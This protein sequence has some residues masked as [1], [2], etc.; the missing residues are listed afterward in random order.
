MAAEV[1]PEEEFRPQQLASE[2]GATALHAVSEPMAE[3]APEPVPQ[4]LTFGDIVFNTGP[5]EGFDMQGFVI[6]LWKQRE[7]L[8]AP[9]TLSLLLERSRL[10]Q[11]P[12][13][14]ETAISTSDVVE[15]ATEKFE[16]LLAKYSGSISQALVS[17]EEP[18]ET[19]A[20]HPLLVLTAALSKASQ[21]KPALKQLAAHVHRIAIALVLANEAA[22]HPS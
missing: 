3:Q 15:Q 22:M 12:D 10:I 6:E 19:H 9:K 20:E 13:S 11:L 14:A 2:A 1:L 7:T 4:E 21:T 17:L 5:R 18:L 16:Q 8:E